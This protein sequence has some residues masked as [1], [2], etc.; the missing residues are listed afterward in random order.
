MHAGKVAAYWYA[1]AIVLV[2]SALLRLVSRPMAAPVWLPAAELAAGVG[3]GALAWWVG[4]G[5][6]PSRLAVLVAGPVIV[7]AAAALYLTHVGYEFAALPA[8]LGTIVA[9]SSAAA[10]VRVR[11]PVGAA[12]GW[13]DV[14]GAGYQ[15]RYAAAQAPPEYVPQYRP[16]HAPT[17]TD[18]SYPPPGGQR[19]GP[20][21]PAPRAPYA[22]PG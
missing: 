11:E 17:L 19:A 7:A 12:A 1:T 14:Y 21:A 8:A 22:A 18:P 5:A 10:F 15:P 9:A 3:I 16:H 20:A 13:A 6:K 2:L 4:R